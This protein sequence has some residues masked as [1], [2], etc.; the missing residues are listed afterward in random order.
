MIEKLIAE[1]DSKNLFT[2]IDT[3]KENPGR[4]QVVEQPEKFTKGQIIIH[5][6]EDYKPRKNIPFNYI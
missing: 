2:A 6:L 1:A 5:L 4:F 3:N